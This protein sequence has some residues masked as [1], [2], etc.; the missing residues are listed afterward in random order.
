MRSSLTSYWK[1]LY[2]AADEATRAE[3]ARKLLQLRANGQ[4][5]YEAKDLA[6]WLKK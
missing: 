3:I 4:P 6:N 5:V 2:I 1:K